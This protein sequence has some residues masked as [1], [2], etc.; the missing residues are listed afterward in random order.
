MAKDIPHLVKGM[1]LLQRGF[2]GRFH[3]AVAANPS[4]GRLTIGRLYLDGTDPDIE[5]AIDQA[6]HKTGFRVV[7][8]D[9]G[10]ARHWEQ[11]HR[12]GNVVAL[13]DSWFNDRKYLS[14]RGVTAGAKAAIILGEAAYNVDYRH[15]IETRAAWRRALRGVFARVDFIALPTLKHLPPR[16][17][18][19]GG[20]AAIDARMLGMQNTVAV[21]YAGNPALAMPVPLDNEKIPITSLQLVGPRMSE[22][23]LLNAGRLIE[24]KVP[25]IG[26][27][28][29]GD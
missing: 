10:F 28:R 29:D 7:R 8:L 20:R 23:A 16:I 14:Q 3:S 2:A 24:A 25:V 26:L 15:A 13:A 22:A 18:L 11:A 21:S 1:D 5:R 12:H 9:A 19:L 27:R 4:A 17:P 6:L